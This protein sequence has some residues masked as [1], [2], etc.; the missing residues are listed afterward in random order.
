MELLKDMPLYVVQWLLQEYLPD[1]DDDDY[2]PK[3]LFDYDPRGS[4]EDNLNDMGKDDA[5][6]ALSTIISRL[7]LLPGKDT[8]EGYPPPSLTAWTGDNE[9]AIRRIRITGQEAWDDWCKQ[10]EETGGLNGSYDEYI[11]EHSDADPGL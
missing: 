9:Y 8:L 4:F 6:C 2:T 7:Y 5:I 1:E 3:E 10:E 11:D